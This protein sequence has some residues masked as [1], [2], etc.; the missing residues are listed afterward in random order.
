VHARFVAGVTLST[1]QPPSVA[2][3]RSVDEAATWKSEPIVSGKCK[4]GV[5]ANPVVRMQRVETARFGEAT[6]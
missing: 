6:F 5:C 1:L 3:V 2:P 4:R